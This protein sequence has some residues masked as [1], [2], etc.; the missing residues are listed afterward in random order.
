[1]A[2]PIRC[3]QCSAMLRVPPGA[4]QMRCPRCKTVLSANGTRITPE[5]EP[6]IPARDRTSA[7]RYREKE[8]PN[9][10]EVPP[11][12]PRKSRPELPED[13]QRKIVDLER[14]LRPARA[15]MRLLA[16]GAAFSC[17]AS[18]LYF[19]AFIATLI[20]AWLLIPLLFLAALCLALHWLCT[21]MGFCYCLW[22]PRT[23]RGMA[24]A[25]VAVMAVHMM[26]MVPLVLS[27]LGAFVLRDVG[28]HTISARGS[29]TAALLLSNIFNNLSTI[30]DLPVYLLG[31]GLS[32]PQLLILPVFCGGL[33]FAKLSLLGIITNHYAT[34]G[35]DPELGY[36]ALRFVYRIFWLVIGGAVFK[37]LLWLLIRLTAGEPLLLMWFVLPISM[38]SLGYFLWWGFAWYSQ[39]EVMFLTVEIIDPKRYLDARKRLEII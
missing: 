20:S 25:G 35:K 10:P 34:E 6:E 17:A 19:L 11:T 4:A 7:P 21:I 26:T 28:F 36:L 12:P 33:E 18:V 14:T 29:L 2:D 39:C 15:G 22:G 37:F 38:M 27:L 32:R 1:M 23:M 24:A 3:P 9:E 30:T 31:D 8:R 5:P 16:Y 13:D